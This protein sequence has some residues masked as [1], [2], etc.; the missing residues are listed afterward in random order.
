[1]QSSG[2]C[3]TVAPMSISVRIVSLALQAAVSQGHGKIMQILLDWG[4]DV[5]LNDEECGTALHVA[6]SEGHEKITEAINFVTSD[7]VRI[8]RDIELLHS[9]LQ[10]AS[11]E[12]HEKVVQIL[13]AR[14]ADINV[15]VETSAVRLK[16]HHPTDMRL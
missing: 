11:A 4:A 15:R 12:G 8:L 13:L 3:W 9:A 10:A 1:M 7:D 5:N 16:R 14:G 2:C 6:A